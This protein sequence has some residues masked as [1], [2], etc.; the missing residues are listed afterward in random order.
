MKFKYKFLTQTQLGRLFGVS[1]HKIGG[2]LVEVSLRTE[3]KRPSDRAHHDGFCT[4][5][6]SGSTGYHW[7]W[8]SQKTVRALQEAGHALV[9]DAPSELV[10]PSVLNGP[11]SMSPTR[12]KEILN[13]D[14]SVAV[15]VMNE[16]SARIV[17]KLLNTSHRHGVIERLTKP[18][19]LTAAA[20]ASSF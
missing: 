2:W 10:E 16:Q 20:M 9:S 4:T 12:T 19:E 15:S 6:P 3:D 5:A 8:N 7:V 11:F 1:S 13:T 18:P 17:L 14:G